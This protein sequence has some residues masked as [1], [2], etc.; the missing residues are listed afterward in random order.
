MGNGH[1]KNQCS[2][3]NI[4]Q[5]PSQNQR[6]NQAEDRAA[7]FIQLGDQRGAKIPRGRLPKTLSTR[8]PHQ[9]RKNAV[10][11]LPSIRQI[12]AGEIPQKP[13]SIGLRSIEPVQLW[14]IGLRPPKLF[15]SLTCDH[16]V[17]RGR[18]VRRKIHNPKFAKFII[19]DAPNAVALGGSRA[20]GRVIRIPRS[21]L[22]AGRRI[23]R[24]NT[25]GP[26][27]V[28]AT[29]IGL[30]RRRVGRRCNRNAALLFQ[31]ASKTKK[32]LPA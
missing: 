12:M 13:N 32:S 28:A 5:L 29:D 26:Q 20:P 9:T 31:F 1:Y 7:A 10:Q 19:A 6:E 25:A 30:V 23:I 27:P 3:P 4:I 8:Y 18:I 17:C 14:V 16:R 24:F 15:Q 21:V 2:V 22:P 11:F